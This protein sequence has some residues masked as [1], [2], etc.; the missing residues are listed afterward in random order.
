MIYLVAKYTKQ[1][2]G[3]KDPEISS[4]MDLLDETTGIVKKDGSNS[5]AKLVMVFLDGEYPYP[6]DLGDDYQKYFDIRV[7]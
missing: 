2:I 1:M 6:I 5:L 3:K 7:V 4:V